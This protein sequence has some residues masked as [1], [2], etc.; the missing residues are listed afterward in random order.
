VLSWHDWTFNADI[1]KASEVALE[2]ITEGPDDTRL[3]FEHRHLERHGGGWQQIREKV[4][5]EG[6]WPMILKQYL[7]AVEQS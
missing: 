1:S 2:F 6:G 4:G 5:A 7:A 3:E